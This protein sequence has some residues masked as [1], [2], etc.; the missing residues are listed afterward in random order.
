MTLVTQQSEERLR[1]RSW[2]VGGLSAVLLAGLEES[3]GDV[4]QELGHELKWKR[5]FGRN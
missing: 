2:S 5:Q 1:T 4:G 3:R